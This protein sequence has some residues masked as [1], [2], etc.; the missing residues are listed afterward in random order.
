M[1]KRPEAWPDLLLTGCHPFKSGGPHRIV[2]NTYTTADGGIITEQEFRDMNDIVVSK[3]RESFSVKEEHIRKALIALGWTPP[4]DEPKCE[5]RPDNHTLVRNAVR[6]AR[7]S[8][9][10]YHVRWS[11]VADIFAVGSTSGHVL[12]REFGLNPDDYINRN[13]K[14]RKEGQ[15]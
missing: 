11:V 12:C 10:G 5:H 2:I 14:V 1:T 13:G 6:N 4:P 7:P 8:S 9:A 3:M 15:R